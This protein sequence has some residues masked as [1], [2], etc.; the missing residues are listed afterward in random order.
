[1]PISDMFGNFASKWLGIHHRLSHGQYIP[2]L[3]FLIYGQFLPRFWLYGLWIYGHFG[4]MVILD[5]WSIL[6]GPDVDHI[7]G[8]Q[9]CLVLSIYFGGAQKVF[10]QVA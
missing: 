9:R 8:T 6:A 10:I 5:I 3:K 4:Y 2:L 7:S 1:M